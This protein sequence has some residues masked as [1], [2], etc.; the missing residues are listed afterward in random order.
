MR[1]PLI[2]TAALLSVTHLSPAA[3]H[4]GKAIYVKLC[5]ECHGHHGEGVEGKYDEPLIGDRS[6][7]AL[8][9]K[10]DKTM[11]EEDPSLC[12]GKDAQQV[13]AYIYD[14]FYSKAAQARQAPTQPDLL[15]LTVPQFQNSVIDLL[16]TFHRGAGH[17][18]PISQ[19]PGLRGLYRGFEPPKDQDQAKQDAK[20]QNRDQQVKNRKRSKLERIDPI[21]DFDFG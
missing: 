10:I 3:E 18:K 16:G 14:A 19:E 8:A 7:D 20:K 13:A 2:I 21:V 1:H 12:A 17:D 9:R 11:P 5:A 15:R 6:P 4:P